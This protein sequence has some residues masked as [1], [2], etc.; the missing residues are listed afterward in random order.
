MVVTPDDLE[1]AL[2][3]H[4]AYEDDAEPEHTAMVRDREPPRVNGIELIDSVG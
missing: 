3:A 1:P 2:R 4:G